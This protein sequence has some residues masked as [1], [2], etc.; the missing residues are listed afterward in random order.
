MLFAKN[1]DYL[2]PKLVFL[3]DWNRKREGETGNRIP[4][5]LGKLISDI[6]QAMNRWHCLRNGIWNKSI[7]LFILLAYS[8]IYWNVED[9]KTKN[10]THVDIKYVWEKM[11]EASMSTSSCYPSPAADMNLASQLSSA[12]LFIFR[13][14]MACTLFRSHKLLVNGKLKL[15]VNGKL[16]R[17]TFPHYGT[18]LCVWCTC[19]SGFCS[20]AM[21]H[22]YIWECLVCRFFTFEI[23]FWGLMSRSTL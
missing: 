4:S 20:L 22:L 13:E 18:F 11:V 9:Y 17:F 15:L 16:T 1:D 23:N 2:E 14:M 10:R 3:S 5:R 6:F 8:S 7:G 21:L 19:P 12:V